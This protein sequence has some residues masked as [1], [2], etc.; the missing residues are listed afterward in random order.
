MS[1]LDPGGEDTV[2]RPEEEFPPA[3]TRCQRLYLDAATGRMTPDPV[4]KETSVRYRGDD[5]EGMAVFDIT[6]D[7]D[8]E[9]AGHMM[10]RLWVAAEGADDMDLFVMAEKL[11]TDGKLLRPIVK[12]APFS[13]FDGAPVEWGTG[14]L[15]VS[16]RRLDPDRSSPSMPFNFHTGEQRLNPGEVVPVEIELCPMAMRWHA[17]Q[18]L[19]VIVAGH[20]ME[21]PQFEHLPP[22]RTRNL[23]DHILHTGGKYATYLLAP[24]V[25]D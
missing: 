25:A 1:V 3:R 7:R 6:F 8:V 17:G 2:H 19:R 9:I 20:N 23:G 16:H 21:K 18:G 13:G 12:G 10:L 24:V 5:G 22:I 14:R 15:R 11:D 4:E